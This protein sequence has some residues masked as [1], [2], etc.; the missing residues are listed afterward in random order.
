VRIKPSQS[1]LFLDPQFDLAFHLLRILLS[2]AEHQAQ[3]RTRKAI[4]F[5]DTILQVTFV[6][7]MD[8]LAVA[9]KENESRWVYFGLSDIEKLEL[10]GGFALGGMMGHGIA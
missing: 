8:H 3:R 1:V 7:E 10:L 4:G 2:T 5:A 6:R 9:D